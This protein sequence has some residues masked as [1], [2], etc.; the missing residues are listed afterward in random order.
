LATPDWTRT[1]EKSFNLLQ[2]G[3]KLLHKC[4]KR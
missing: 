3:S 4:A 2:S 1:R